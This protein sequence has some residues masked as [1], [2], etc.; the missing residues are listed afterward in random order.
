MK[1]EATSSATVSLRDRQ[2]DMKHALAH[3]RVAYRR[4]LYTSKRRR[5]VPALGSLFYA[6]LYGLKKINFEV[7]R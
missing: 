2:S 1:D 7:T 5:V 6:R 3:G 4:G